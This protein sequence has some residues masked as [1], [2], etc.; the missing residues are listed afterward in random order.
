MYATTQ[1]ERQT[2]KQ[3][4]INS[5]TVGGQRELR[6]NYKKVEILLCYCGY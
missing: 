5:I 1:S 6:E 2:N 4:V 3:M